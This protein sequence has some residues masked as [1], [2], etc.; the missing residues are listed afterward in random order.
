MSCQTWETK[1][2]KKWA[3]NRNMTEEKK[4]NKVDVWTIRYIHKNEVSISKVQLSR[5]DE[6]YVIQTASKTLFLLSSLFV[7]LFFIFISV[8]SI[9]HWYFKMTNVSVGTVKKKLHRS[10]HRFNC[11]NNDERRNGRSGWKRHHKVNGT[12]FYLYPKM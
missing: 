8:F 1:V 3:K 4:K 11:W 2:R 6:L 10:L 12:Q 5:I 7:P 9:F